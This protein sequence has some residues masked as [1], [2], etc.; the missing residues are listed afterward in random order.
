MFCDEVIIIKTLKPSKAEALTVYF[1]FKQAFF[2][3]LLLFTPGYFGLDF[4][5]IGKCSQLI[6]IP[7]VVA[8]CFV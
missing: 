6:R 2:A 8:T 7:F 1:D 3:W 5:L 4:V